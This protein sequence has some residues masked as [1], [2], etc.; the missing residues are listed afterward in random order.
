M[1]RMNTTKDWKKLVSMKPKEKTMKPVGKYIVIKTIEEQIKTSSGILLSASDVDGFRY[2]KGKVVKPGTDVTV[3]NEDDL[4]YYDKNSGVTLIIDEIPLTI[5]Q[6][7][8]VVIVIEGGF[9]NS[10]SLASKNTSTF[11]L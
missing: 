1:S 5:I 7:R 8:D 9:L 11:A 2:K 10:P 4:I 3:I 6:E